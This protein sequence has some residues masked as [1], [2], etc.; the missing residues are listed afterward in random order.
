MTPAL[1]HR[2]SITIQVAKPTLVS[3]SPETGKRQLIPIES[4]VVSGELTGHVLPGGVDSQIIL[5][6]GTCQ[7]SARYAIQVEQGCVYIENNG[8]RRIPEAYRKHLFADDMSF[9]SELPPEDIYF[10]T[11]PRFEVDTPALSW[12]TDSLFICA[13]IR[14]R[15]GVMLDFYRV[16]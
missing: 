13:G 10:R 3:R 11:V 7:L 1:T 5:P 12:L 4:G 16:D 8:I 15:D 6:D 9:F 14:T 2:F